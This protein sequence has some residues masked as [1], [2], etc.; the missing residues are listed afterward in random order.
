MAHIIPDELPGRVGAFT[1]TLD[2][3]YAGCHGLL[4]EHMGAVRVRVLWGLLMNIGQERVRYAIFFDNN[5]RFIDSAD[6]F[7]K[8]LPIAQRSWELFFEKTYNWRYVVHGG[9]ATL[10]AAH[11]RDESAYAARKKAL[12]GNLQAMTRALDTI[13]VDR[14]FEVCKHS[15]DPRCVE[16]YRENERRRRETLVEDARRD[17]AKEL[18]GMR[19]GSLL[20]KAADLLTLDQDNVVNPASAPFLAP[21]ALEVIGHL[22]ALILRRRPQ[23]PAAIRR[24][25]YNHLKDDY[26]KW[27]RWRHLPY[28]TRSYDL[29]FGVLI[30]LSPVGRERTT[31]EEMRRAL[32]FYTGGGG[33]KVLEILARA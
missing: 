6:H 21:E 14:A 18:G 17:A 4:R 25:V 29:R 27:Y 24:L 2:R 22:D 11:A 12:E 9:A 30:F 26:R 8:Y 23:T 33:T 7:C 16:T 32:L 1:P 31:W 28:V 19:K 20:K 15:S 13:D 5:H 3:V 10:D